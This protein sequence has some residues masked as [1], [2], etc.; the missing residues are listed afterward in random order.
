[1]QDFPGGFITPI[2]FSDS[3]LEITAKVRLVNGPHRCAGRL[4]VFQ[5]ERWGTVCGNGWDMNDAIVVCRQLGCGIA[6][7]APVQA[8][9][10]QGSDPIWMN[11]VSCIGTESSISECLSS[12]WG[13]QL[14]TH[15]DDAGVECSGELW[16]PHCWR[17]VDTQHTSGGLEQDGARKVQF[18]DSEKSFFP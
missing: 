11:R 7:S 2:T 16:M 10:G 9:F 13:I 12:P 15:M 5:N 1:M 18:C 6:L 14:C 4:E 8:H 17:Q 3:Q